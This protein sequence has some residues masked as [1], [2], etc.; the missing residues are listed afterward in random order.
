MNEGAALFGLTLYRSAPGMWVV[1]HTTRE[2]LDAY[3][4][5]LAGRAAGVSCDVIHSGAK[6]A[7]P[8]YLF[9]EFKDWLS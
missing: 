9:L 5:W 4:A 8:F 3:A 7:F 6:G 1:G 2:P